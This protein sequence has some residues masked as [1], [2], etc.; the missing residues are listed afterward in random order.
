MK[1]RMVCGSIVWFVVAWVVGLCMVG[2]VSDAATVHVDDFGARGDGRTYDHGAIQRA[3]QAAGDGGIVVFGAG[4]VYVQC[5]EL[6]PR[7]NQTFRGN[8]ATLKRCNAVTTRLTAAASA[9]ATSIRVADASGYSV[10]MYITPLK[11]HG[12]QDGESHERHRITAMRG[13]TITFTNGLAQSYPAAS[14]VTTLLHQIAFEYQVSDTTFE[15]LVFDGN[16][17][18]NDHYVA[19]TQNGAIHA[20]APTTIRDCVFRNLPGDGVGAYASGILIERNTFKNTNSSAIHLSGN[21][22]DADVVI[23]DNVMRRTNQ[24]AERAQ[25]AEGAI[26]I[27][28]YNNHVRVR[29]NRVE[30]IPVAFIGRF[31]KDMRDWTIEDN[32]ID[33]A[34]GLFVGN[35]ADS[36]TSPLAQIVWRRNHATNV[37]MSFLRRFGGS[38][39]GFDLIDNTILR[40]AVMLEG[41]R[42]SVMTRNTIQACQAEPLVI[43]NSA[44]LTVR[45]NNLSATCE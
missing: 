6:R 8:G 37:G 25:H 39:Q 18:N 30:S 16:R 28:L 34:R 41:L 36:R 40:G 9:G 26:T 19:W 12:F 2:Q 22:G 44:G 14:L 35:G 13:Q 5:Q 42:Q 3:I 21:L 15:A 32:V 17:A 7:S 33:G 4:K 24:Q 27:S 1:K 10:G 43:Q 45:D 11:G 20:A 23:Q 31:H 29:R 38:A